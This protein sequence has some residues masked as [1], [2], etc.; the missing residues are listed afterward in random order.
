MVIW[1]GARRARRGFSLVELMVTVALAT[2]VLG[3]MVPLF[4]TVLHRTS[5]DNLRNVAANIAQDRIEQVRLLSYDSI[6]QTNLNS[7]P[8]PASSFGDG[9]F[10]PV[11]YVTGSS[12]P[13]NITYTVNDLTQAK[14]VTVAA[15][16]SSTGYT[17]TMQTIVKDPAAGVTSTTVPVPSPS[18]T[19]SGLSITVSFKDW[20]DVT[21]QGVTVKRVQ[22]DVTPN[23]TT[24]P[25]PTIQIP[26]AVSPT[27]TWTGLTG[28]TSFTYTVTCHSQYIT[29]T[30]PPF[31]LL[32]DA[33]LKFDTHPG[34]S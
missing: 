9:K 23:V 14:K 24:T 19:I 32:K 10:G 27:V 16:W 26:S 18:P 4:V 25:T 1:L 3:A 6:T 21:S 11:Y 29:E 15:T 22:T 5:G 30:S 17:T 8:S 33:R 34:G 28:G 13:Y 31:H 7:P 20:S 2:I 12:K